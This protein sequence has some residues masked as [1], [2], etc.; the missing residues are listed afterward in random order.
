[1]RR[2]EPMVLVIERIEGRKVKWQLRKGVE[3]I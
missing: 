3:L 2:N 1:M